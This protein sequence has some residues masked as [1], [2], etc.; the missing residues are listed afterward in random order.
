MAGDK[1]SGQKTSGQFFPFHFRQTF[2]DAMGQFQK[3]GV[4]DEF[5]S[6]RTIGAGYQSL[7]KQG[8]CVDFFGSHGQAVGGLGLVRVEIAFSL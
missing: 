8:H 7:G 2:T 4:C 3:C 5:R 6:F 1:L